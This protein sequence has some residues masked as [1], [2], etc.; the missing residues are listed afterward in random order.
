MRE[1][2][3]FL[4]DFGEGLLPSWNDGFARRSILAFVSGAIAEGTPDFVPP[5]ARVALLL[6]DG[7]LCCE[8]PL[9]LQDAFVID[10]VQALAAQHPQLLM[11]LSALAGG[12][13]PGE[14]APL[15]SIRAV[16][17]E[18]NADQFA[19]SIL[20]WYD[21]AEHPHLKQPLQ[22]LV[23]QPALELVDYLRRHEFQLCLLCRGD[24]DFVRTIAP[25]AYG[26]PREQVLHFTELGNLA[27]PAS[28]G[29]ITIRSSTDSDLSG[30]VNISGAR[31]LTL[32][33][34]HDDAAR[35]FAYEDSP[36][37]LPPAPPAHGAVPVSMKKDW[38]SVFAAATGA[39]HFSGGRKWHSK[40]PFGQTRSV[41]SARTSL[42]HITVRVA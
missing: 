7:V 26:I 29:V 16:Q 6:H 3:Q 36:Y 23:Y 14:P 40:S 22:Q 25:R 9:C 24:V 34:H 38:K 33:V 42:Q 13:E 2:D 12:A 37:A 10:R 5:G 19:Q 39:D 31:F 17:P 21:R 4:F 18:L 27:L 8:Q 28:P 20:D 32:V 11:A 15:D 1:H 41:S 35:E 30:L